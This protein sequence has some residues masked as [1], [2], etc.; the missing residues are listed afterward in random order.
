MNNIKLKFEIKKTDELSSDEINSIVLLIKKYLNKNFD[1]IKFIN[2]YKKNFLKFSYHGLVKK[3][4]KTL[5][6]YSVIPYLFEYQNQTFKIAQSVDTVFDE[7]IRGNPYNLKKIAELVYEK[8]KLNDFKLVYGLPNKQIYLI[9]QR[10]LKWE[11]LFYVKKYIKVPLIETLFS[12]LFKIPKYL[13]INNFLLNKF[14]NKL[15]ENDFK[16][17]KKFLFNIIYIKNLRLIQS[18]TFKNK[19]YFLKFNFKLFIFF[20]SKKIY[21]PFFFLIPKLFDKNKIIISGKF[22]TNNQN[23]IDIIKKR[24]MLTLKDLDIY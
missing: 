17:L 1:D 8:I 16:I 3:N 9:R 13:P 11:N 7:E 6:I 12:K 2:K 22:I 18:D 4:D 15:E 10:V 24:L 23:E 5:G 19:K 20:S 14:E 21:I